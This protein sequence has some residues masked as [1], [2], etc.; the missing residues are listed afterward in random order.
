MSSSKLFRNVIIGG[1]VAAGTAAGA[2]APRSFNDK[3]RNF[4]PSVPMRGTLT[5]VCTTP[6]PA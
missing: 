5:V 6:V 1:A 2:L 3:R 4:V